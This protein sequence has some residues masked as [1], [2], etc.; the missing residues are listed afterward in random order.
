MNTI[1]PIK[2]NLNKLFQMQRVLSN[3]TPEE[4]LLGPEIPSCLD[5]QSPQPLSH[6][7]FQHA[8]CQGGGGG[9]FS[10]ITH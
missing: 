5:I 1:E 9:Y 3:L 4:S 10:G 6:E 2:L 7:N 8:I